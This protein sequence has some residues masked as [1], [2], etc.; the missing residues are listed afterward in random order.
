MEIERVCAPVCPHPGC[1]TCRTIV[2]GMVAAQLRTIAEGL[3][4]GICVEALQLAKQHI[5]ERSEA[6]IVLEQIG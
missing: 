3:R 2:V 6:A 4:A 5:V 1:S